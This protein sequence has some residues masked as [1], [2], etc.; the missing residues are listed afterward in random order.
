MKTTFIYA[1]CEPGTRTVR[2][3]GKA[4]RPKRRFTNHLSVSIKQKSHLGNWIRLLSSRGEKPELVVLREVP[5]DQWAAAE[6][7]YIRLA[8]GCKMNLVNSTDGGEGLNNPS[9]ETRKKIS[10]GN[11]GKIQTPESNEKRRVALTGSKNHF[12]G[13]KHS[14]KTLESLTGRERTPEHCANIS[15]SKLGQRKGVKRPLRSPEW[16]AAISAGKTGRSGGK[17]SKSSSRYLGVSWDGR[18]NKWAARIGVAGKTVHLGRFK[19]E[20]DAALAYDAAASKFF[21]ARATLNIQ[22]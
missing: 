4:D 22:T 11:T 2:Y 15:K 1:L 14:P 20:L 21:G 12:F 7:R 17:R 10:E 9:L 13:R 16:C 8:R 6:E 5:A 19:L 3:I 18:R